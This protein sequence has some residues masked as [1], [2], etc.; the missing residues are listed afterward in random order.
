[1]NSQYMDKIPWKGKPNQENITNTKTKFQE[2]LVIKKKDLK[3]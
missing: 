1:M 3:L 2:K